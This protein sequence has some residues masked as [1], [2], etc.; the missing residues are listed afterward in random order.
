MPKKKNKGGGAGGGQVVAAAE[1]ITAGV[2][3]KAES[4]GFRFASWVGLGACRRMR[5]AR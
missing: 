4:S 2:T 1:I 3:I 5:S